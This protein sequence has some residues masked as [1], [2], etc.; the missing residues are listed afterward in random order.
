MGSVIYLGMKPKLTEVERFWSKVQKTRDCW[1]WTAGKAKDNYGVFW[2]K[3][4]Q[5]S[6]H[7]Y[8]Y[9]LAGA[10]IPE[11]LSVCHTCDNPACVNPAHLFVGTVLDN[12]L[13]R[14]AKNRQARHE[15]QGLA[16]LT[17]ELV[18]QIRA[19]TGTYKKLAEKYGVGK[20]AIFRIRHNLTWK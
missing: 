20:T 1:I 16:K 6:A 19:D 4:R 11:G 3:G 17:E 18:S 9:E 15:K 8:S 13:D 12:A 2:S 7:R 14:N 5:V 10:P